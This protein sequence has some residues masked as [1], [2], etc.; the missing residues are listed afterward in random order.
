VGKFAL[1]V[2]LFAAIVYLGFWLLER[3]RIQREDPSWTPRRVRRRRAVAPDDDEDFL[4]GLNR[5]GRRPP[6]QTPDD[7]R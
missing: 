7:P 2:V 6:D 4:R 3:R 1:V 5:P